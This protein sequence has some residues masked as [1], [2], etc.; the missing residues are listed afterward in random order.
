MQVEF[1]AYYTAGRQCFQLSDDLQ[2]AFLD[3][4]RLLADCSHMAGSDDS[5]QAWAKKYDE[6]VEDLLRMVSSLGEALDNFGVVITQAGFNYEQ[7]EYNAMVNPSIAPPLMPPTRPPVCRYYGTS[8]SAGGPGNGLVDAGVKIANKVGITVPDGDTNKLQ[9]A[10]GVWNKLKTGY[11]DTIQSVM[12]NT[13]ILFEHVDAPDAQSVRDRLNGLQDTVDNVLTVCGELSSMAATEGQALAKLRHDQINAIL[14]AL[15]DALETQAVI[16]IAAAFVSF[17]ASLAAETVEAAA[18]L[19]TYGKRI[20]DA[21][22]A[23]RAAKEAEEATV[24]ATDLGKSER[25]VED[26]K[27]LKPE[28]AQEPEPRPSTT[29]APNLRTELD[30]SQT[31]TQGNLPAKG[32]PPNGYLVKRD[33]QGAVTNYIEYDADGNAVKRVDLTGATHAGV[34]T[35]HVVDYD[36]NVNPTTGEKFPRPNNRNVRPA[37]P[38]EIP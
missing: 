17:G 29:P 22:E 12:K 19:A 23:W 11:T 20:R 24:V 1:S 2:Q 10:S 27:A 15:A 30:N 18:T 21:V 13:V 3:N 33:P 31:W 26:T 28:S 8:P 25:V 35:P 5:G 38:E 6:R 37:T 9:Q 34:P 7:A 14:G 32:G 16:N 36:I 4:L